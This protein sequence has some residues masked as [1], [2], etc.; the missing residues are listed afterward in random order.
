VEFALSSEQ[1]MLHDSA[2]RFLADGADTAGWSDF[3][4]MG[5]LALRVPE[6]AGGLGGSLEDAMVLA[7]EIGRA[8][9][10]VP[11]ATSA[12]LAAALVEAVAAGEQ[13]LGLLEA[14]ASGEQ[15]IVPALYEPGRRYAILPEARAKASTGGYLLSGAKCLVSGGVKDGLLL[16]SATLDDGAIGLFLVGP[17]HPALIVRQYPTLDDR[18]A[19]DLSLAE[20]VVPADA[21]LG[22]VSPEILE[23]F[24]DQ[25]RL[26]LCA[27]T[28]G[29]LDRCIELTAAYLKTRTQFGQPL[30]NFQ[31]LQHS[32]VEMYVETDLIRSSIYQALAA[33]GRQNRRE[34]AR[35]VSS[36]WV[37]TFASAK[38]IAGMAVH[39]HGAIGMTCEYPV[40]HYLRRIMLSERSFGDVE[41]HLARYM[42]GPQQVTSAG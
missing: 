41:F 19:S 10:P 11:F 42:A 27:E 32:V 25:A 35:A 6:Q 1:E 2:R 18:V 15:L 3:A 30:A 36:C 37:K 23:D 24:I 12:V 40:G 5:W 33:S 34:A 17:D 16:V 20:A 4:A 21:L 39:L 14:I 9:S 26:T 28:L 38:D 29:A 22:L 31:A 8:L 13:R 7:E